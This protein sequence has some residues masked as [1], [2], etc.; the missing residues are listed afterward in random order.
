[1]LAMGVFAYEDLS[2]ELVDIPLEQFA[3]GA[4][5]LARRHGRRRVGVIGGS[6]GGELALLLGASFPDRFSA[7]VGLCPAHVVHG[8]LPRDGRAGT[9]A[10]T[11]NGTALPFARFPEVEAAYS[12]SFWREREA[13]HRPM[14][15]EGW[16]PEVEA[17]A[18]IPV[19]RSRAAILLISGA[20]DE[21][22]PAAIASERAMRR[23]RSAGYAHP[24]RSVVF[25]GAGHWVT[26]PSGIDFGQSDGMVHPVLGA[27]MPLGGTAKAN[28]EASLQGFRI[29][30]DWLKQYATDA[31]N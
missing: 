3:E 9:A 16:T 30:C 17:Q 27:W 31:T 5:W 22:W 25:E 26:R 12:P 24:C 14:Y 10:W 13:T 19:E 6:R 28:A 2:P 20:A 15:L 7:V 18:G 11:L 21:L 29:A 1:V 23:L 4:D 8:G